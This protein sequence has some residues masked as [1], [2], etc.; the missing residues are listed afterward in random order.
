M[1]SSAARISLYLARDAPVVAIIRRGPTKWTQMLKWNLLD[2]SIESGQWFRGRVYSKRS[3]ISPS[4]T[5]L[6][7]FAADWSKRVREFGPTW[8]AISRVPYFTALALWPEDSTWG[9][10]GFFVEEY[11]VA[12]KTGDLELA[13]GFS[14]PTK[15]KHMVAN[16]P[17]YPKKRSNW[18]LS[19]LSIDT[20]IQLTADRTSH[21][22]LAHGRVLLKGCATKT[23]NDYFFIREQGQ[24]FMIEQG[25][26][27]EA[28]H[29]GR[30][31]IAAAGK[32]YVLGA[33][34]PFTGVKDLPVL[35][36]LN[37]NKPN[38]FKS[39]AEMRNWLIE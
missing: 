9:G 37:D 16:L 20:D 24:D 30:T 29:R 4:G 5:Y 8:T 27:L 31:L 38:R 18:L 32:L 12:F 33:D 11:E 10:G 1:T 2:D 15:F 23:H 7:Y 35:A 19:D 13:P 21:Q 26:G 17:P 22:E 6:I 28:D 3:A 39:P 36:N 34:E 14:V 25:Q